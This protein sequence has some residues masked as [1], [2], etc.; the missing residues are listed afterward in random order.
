LVHV[1]GARFESTVAA[2]RALRE[3]RARYAIGDRDA[4]VRPLGTTE[5]DAPTSDLILAARFGPD[6]IPEVVS[7]LERLGGEV[8]VERDERPPPS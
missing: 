8:I 5:Y 2:Q 4:E 1:L 6:V 3:L 7:M